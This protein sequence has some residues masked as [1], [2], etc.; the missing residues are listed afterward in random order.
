MLQMLNRFHPDDI[1]LIHQK[2]SLMRWQLMELVRS[3]ANSFDQA[4]LTP[5]DRV[6]MLLP[7]SL[8]L[9]VAYY[10]CLANGL[11]AVP[12]NDRLAQHELGRI[13]DHASPRL[14]ISSATLSKHYDLEQKIARRDISLL[15]DL[16][17]AVPDTPGDHPPFP[18]WPDSQAAIIFL[19][20]WFH[21]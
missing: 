11:V 6:V 16:H 12:A 10:A 18:K 15:K 20:Q 9:L 3:L 13:L 21:R 5:G 4:G 14:V 19:Y 1:I 2:G 8:E 17:Q 7:N